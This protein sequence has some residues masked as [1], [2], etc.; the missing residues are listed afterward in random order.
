MAISLLV[1][2]VAL[3]AEAQSLMAEARSADRSV[4]FAVPAGASTMANEATAP[5]TAAPEQGAVRWEFG[6]GSVSHIL[7]PRSLNT[8][9]KALSEPMRRGTGPVGEMSKGA[10]YANG[11]T[12]ASDNMLSVRTRSNTI[13]VKFQDGATRDISVRLSDLL[14]NGYPIGTQQRR[15]S[16]QLELERPDGMKAS[17][18][19]EVRDHGSG[20]VWYG[21]ASAASGSL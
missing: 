21:L 3:R 12:Q 9:G 6:D 19:V 16:G 1:S 18:L 20:Q 17:L 2:L 8:P 10:P 11:I 13:I 14:G 5:V 15:V 7:P 4:E